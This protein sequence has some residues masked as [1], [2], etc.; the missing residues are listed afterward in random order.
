MYRL[1]RTEG[2]E[3][4]LST[5]L[6]KLILLGKQRQ[7]TVNLHV[8]LA[9]RN[10]LFNSRIIWGLFEGW[11][12]VRIVRLKAAECLPRSSSKSSWFSGLKKLKFPNVTNPTHSPPIDRA[13]QE[14]KLIL[15]AT[16]CLSTC[17]KLLKRYLMIFLVFSSKRALFMP[18]KLMF[19]N[20]S[21]EQTEIYSFSTSSAR[22]VVSQSSLANRNQQIR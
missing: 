3:Q 19:R 18:L 7:T 12:E 4:S 13:V 20:S 14:I 2:C 10:A 22:A 17:K 15:K 1:E 8:S 6:S 11:V 16:E 21:G 9:W 5:F